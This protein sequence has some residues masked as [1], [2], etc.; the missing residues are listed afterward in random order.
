M[1]LGPIEVIVIGFP[2]NQFNGG[3]IPELEQLVESDTISIVDGLLVM[4]TADGAVE[5][6]EFDQDGGDPDAARLAALF[7]RL[8]SLISDEDVNELA[9][10]LAPDS[11]AA[12]L[13]FEHTWAKK[14]AG[15]V[16][17]SGG[18]VVAREYIPES[19]VEAAMAAAQNS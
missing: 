16:E 6:F 8:D 15:A 7:D 11:S 17:G 5:F 2:G 10:D 1:T 12:I 4:K 3:I 9:A 19:I 13:V 14:L 18:F